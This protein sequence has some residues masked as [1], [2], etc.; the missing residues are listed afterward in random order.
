MIIKQGC[1]LLSSVPL[2][3]V[4]LVGSLSSICDGAMPTL[5]KACPEGAIKGIRACD[6]FELDFNRKNSKVTHLIIK[7]RDQTHEVA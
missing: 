5:P 6:A 3:I 4:I 2:A 7:G 1:T